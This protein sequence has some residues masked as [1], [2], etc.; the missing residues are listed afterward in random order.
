ME[1]CPKC[2]SPDKWVKL[3][4][5]QEL[6]SPKFRGWYCVPC[7]HVERP[8]GRERLFEFEGKEKHEPVN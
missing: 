7:N 5:C 6:G 2:G 1:K 4:D 8:V 3:W